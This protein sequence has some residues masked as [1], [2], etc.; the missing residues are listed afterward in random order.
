MPSSSK[1]EGRD[2]RAIELLPMVSIV[3]RLSQTSK[4]KIPESLS[5]GQPMTVHFPFDNT[6]AQLPDRFFARVEPT[7][8]KAPRLI[9]LNRDLA[10]QLGLDPEW[11][12]SPQG[13]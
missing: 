12:A 13:I 11:L 1:A 8:V 10:S 4:E 7:P 3:L 5:E 2:P 6:Y 9:R